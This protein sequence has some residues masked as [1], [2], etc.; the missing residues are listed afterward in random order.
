M[1][2]QYLFREYDIRGNANEELTD[3]FVKKIGMALGTYFRR[4]NA[5][6]L[7]VGRDCRLHSDRL[8]KALLEGLFS[9]G[10]DVVDIGVVATPLL[11]FSVFHFHFDGGIQITG[12][13]NPKTDNGFKI[14][15]GE[16]PFFGTQLQMLR[17]MIETNDFDLAEKRGTLSTLSV[18]N[19][20]LGFVKTKLQMGARR[21]KIVVDAGNGTGGVF[22]V[23]LLKEAGFEVVDLF[24]EMDG[25]FPNHHPDPTVEK[26]L[27]H[28][29]NEVKRVGA[30]IGLALDGDADRLGAVD[31]QGR[32]VF[33]DQLLLLLAKAILLEEPGA[34]FLGEVKCS[35]AVYDEI[36]KAGGTAVMWK[37]GH[38]LL[39]EKMKE[40]GAAL[41]G[42][43]SGHLFFAH[44]YLGYD[45]AIYA[46]ARLVE[47]LSNSKHPF[48]THIDMLPK[49]HN[50]PEIRKDVSEEDK[51]EIVRQVILRF[52]K[53]PTAKVVQIDG[54]RIQC[55]DGWALVRASNTQSALVM[56]FEA[57]T[58]ER[59]LEIQTWVETEVF[60]IEQELKSKNVGQ[61]TPM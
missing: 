53:E 34:I 57:N 10:I 15:D 60:A 30:E 12:S 61:R 37:V 26:N 16:R 58:K 52:Q 49:L 20:Y 59:L 25:S 47:L 29:Q 7:S 35:Q 45:D 39:K 4:K 18:V 42:E 36:E 50:T 51:F 9:T 43:M 41:A 38:S 33:G 14:L 56:R 48:S 32:I 40:I 8:H 1:M 22:L 44:R 28:L 2:N 55:Q 5:K 46:G 11:Y 6:I 54:A 13:H 31:Q 17:T 24:C 19:D 3:D 21:F 23:P 27:L